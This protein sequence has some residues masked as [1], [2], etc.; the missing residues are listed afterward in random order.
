MKKKLLSIILVAMMSL[1]A[2]P[3]TAFAEAGDTTTTTTTTTTA[4]KTSVT[5]TTAKTTEPTTATT[6]E[7]VTTEPPKVKEE[8]DL[9]NNTGKIDLTVQKYGKEYSLV[10][11]FFEKGKKKIKL[12]ADLEW[13]E[14]VSSYAYVSA[15]LKNIDFA[16]A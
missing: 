9:A 4:V 5:T 2:I 11:L 10:S 14:N 3:C 16:N 8:L 12:K 7:P 1:N 13:D 15:H 6:T